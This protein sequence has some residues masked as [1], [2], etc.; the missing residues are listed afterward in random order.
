M[1]KEARSQAVKMLRARRRPKEIAA[2]TGLSTD[3]VKGLRQR[4]RLPP[5]PRGR[6]DG[7]VDREPR[8]RS[9]AARGGPSK[10]RSQIISLLVGGEKAAA[11]ARAIG[12]HPGTANRAKRRWI[13]NIPRTRPEAHG[14]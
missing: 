7:D 8:R 5:F 6:Q 1:T 2:A 11:V 3:S 4:L 10:T 14:L 12:V 13:D 9:R